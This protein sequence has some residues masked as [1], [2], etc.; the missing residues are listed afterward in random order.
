[1]VSGPIITSKKELR[2]LQELNLFNRNAI[3]YLSKE[4]TDEF[5]RFFDRVLFKIINRGNIDMD[6][7]IDDPE[8]RKEIADDERRN[9][10]RN[11]H[12]L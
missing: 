10:K 9:N 8:L 1:M 3:D 5:R 6:P 11:D 12:S 2:V 7:S 4:E